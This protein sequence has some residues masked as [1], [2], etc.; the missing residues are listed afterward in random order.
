MSRIGNKAITIPAGVEVTIGAGNEVTVKGPKGT[1]TRQF[2]PEMTIEVKD[3]VLT[4]ARPNETK[5]I[6]QLHGTTRALINNMVEGVHKEFT[7]ELEVVG[8]GYRAA[9]SGKKLTLNVGYSHQ[10]EFEIEDGLTVTCPN[11]N[12]ITITGIDKQRVGE[13]AAVVR[14]TRK[15]EPYKGKGI[16]YKNE[17]IRRKEGKTAGKK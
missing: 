2:S 11:P 16:K 5:R 15:P 4:V 12:A 10:V 17:H 3:G 7:K 8:I 9:V 1:L 6:K 13:F 14:A